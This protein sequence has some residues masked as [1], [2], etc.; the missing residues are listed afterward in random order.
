S[1]AGDGYCSSCGHK[2]DAPNEEGGRAT[3]VVVPVGAT[4]GG[5]EIVAARAPDEF[6]VRTPE[7]SDVTI[8]VGPAAEID[9]ERSALEKGGRKNAFARVM[10]HGNDDKFGAYLT[11]GAPPRASKRIGDAD[12]KDRMTLERALAIVGAVLDL[13]DAIERAGLAWEPE[14]EDLYVA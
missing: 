5:G 12:A 9:R 13:A 4:V 1:D 14:R 7:G 8:V 2:L 6:V 3:P 10:G 11:L